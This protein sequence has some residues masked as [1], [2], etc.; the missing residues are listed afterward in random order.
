[1]PIAHAGPDIQV[2]SAGASTTVLLDGTASHDP[3]G[4]LVAYRWSQLSG[5]SLAVIVSPTT[6][7]TLVTSLQVGLYQ[8]ELTVTDNVGTM[9]RDAIVVTVQPVPNE[10]PVA[11]AGPDQQL[12]RAG[13]QPTTAVLDGSSSFDPD[14]ALVAYA[15]RQVAGPAL[16]TI[17]SPGSAQTVV[18]GLQMG[19][20][21]FELKVTDNRGASAA[22]TALVAVVD[23][24]PQPGGPIARAGRNLLVVFPATSAVLDGSAS[25]SAGGA[26]VRFQWD[27][28]GGPAAGCASGHD[29]ARLS[30]SRLARGT[31]LYR[32]TVTDDQGRRDADEVSVTVRRPVLAK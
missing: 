6:A 25:S 13:S 28:V 7:Q 26:L 20:H 15:W 9:A 4:V 19:L 2:L 1:M 22:D 14:G 29:T 3:G 5:P 11:D 17:I 8:F 10:G 24:A 12:Q 27:Q 30:L 32:L 31:Y 23:A 21:V 18:S 16:A